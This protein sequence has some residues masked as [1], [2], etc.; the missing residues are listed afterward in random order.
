MA[1]KVKHKKSWKKPKLALIT[2]SKTQASIDGT[3]PDGLGG[4]S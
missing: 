1:L 4:T 2:I 3:T